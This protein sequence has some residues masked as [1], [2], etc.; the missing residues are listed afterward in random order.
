[1]SVILFS[2]KNKL[3]KATGEKTNIN[4]NEKIAKTI[5]GVKKQW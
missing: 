4:K 3:K 1:V 5:V 2:C